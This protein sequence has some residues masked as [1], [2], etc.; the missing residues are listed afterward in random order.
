MKKILFAIL[1]MALTT[2]A[3]GYSYD[4]EIASNAAGTCDIK[5]KFGDV[6]VGT[7]SK[8]FDEAGTQHLVITTNVV[9]NKTEI[10]GYSDSSNPTYHDYQTL[11]SPLPVTHVNYVTIDIDGISPP[12]D[13]GEGET[14]D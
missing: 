14:E 1:L 11:G 3:F 8:H 6:T 2:A 12:P 9:P 4:F 10:H 5:L 7:G 13:P